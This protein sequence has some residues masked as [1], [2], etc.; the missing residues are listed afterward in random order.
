MALVVLGLQA[1]GVPTVSSDKLCFDRTSTALSM[2]SLQGTFTLR[3]YSRDSSV[4]IPKRVPEHNAVLRLPHQTP[5][6]SMAS[7]DSYATKRGV[8]QGRRTVQNATSDVI[9]WHL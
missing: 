5:S 2:R 4:G 1:R 9:D 8:K 3:T 6:E 7:F